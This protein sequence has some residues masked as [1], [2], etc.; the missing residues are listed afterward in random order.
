MRRAGESGNG[1]V[2]SFG[3]L[4]IWYPALASTMDAA[5]TLATNGAP[6]GTV[7]ETDHQTAG[8]GRQGRVWTAAPGSGLLTSW[9]LRTSHSPQ[10]VGVLSP[11]VALAVIRAVRRAAPDAPL[12]F[13]WPNDVLV[14]GRKL[15]GILLTSR[16]HGAEV[17]IIAGIG[18]NVRAESVPDS[19]TATALDEWHEGASAGELRNCIAFE[20]ECVWRRFEQHPLLVAGDH[21]ELESLLMWKDELV[22]VYAGAG[23]VTGAVLGVEPDGSL[24]LQSHETGPVVT[25]HAGEVVRGPRDVGAN[26]ADSYRILS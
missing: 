7:V 23:P 9:I 16:S 1:M 5:S 26:S 11:L 17:T 21:A 6:I 4:R 25:V 8:R 12:A 13:K 2:C 3:A 22:E 15:A 14:D 24:R 10:C 19:S 20:L 18:V